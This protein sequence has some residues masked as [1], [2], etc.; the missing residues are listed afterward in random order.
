MART[1]SKSK[2]TLVPLENPQSPIWATYIGNSY[3]GSLALTRRF[4]IYDWA[5]HYVGRWSSRGWWGSSHVFCWVVRNN[6]SGVESSHICGMPSR[7]LS[8]PRGLIRNSRLLPKVL[9]WTRGWLWR[10]LQPIEQLRC[11]GWIWWTGQDVFCWS[12]LCSK[13]PNPGG[14]SEVYLSNPRLL[15]TVWVPSKRPLAQWGTGNQRR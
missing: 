9:G 7:W 8:L 1:W 5:S 6:S 10:R 13:F 4:Y 14:A 11:W 15:T 2:V 12:I 3:W